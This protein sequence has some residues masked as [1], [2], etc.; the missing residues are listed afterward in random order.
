MWLAEVGRFADAIAFGS[1]AV[2]IAETA[3]HPYSLLN[4]LVGLGFALVRKGDVDRAIPLLERACE[5]SA[6][7][8]QTI[9]SVCA[10]SLATA[11]GLAGRSPDAAAV[12]ANPLVTSISP[13]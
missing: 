6:S 5:V 2:E 1:E 12:L 10:T 11:Y 8:S 7:L 9:W 4:A 3:D 13:R